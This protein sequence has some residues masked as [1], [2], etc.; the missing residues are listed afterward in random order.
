MKR[1]NLCLR[2]SYVLFFILFIQCSTNNKSTERITKRNSIL[3][4]IHPPKLQEYTTSILSF[5]AK[6]DSTTNCKPAFDKAMENCRIH[7]GAKITVPAGCYF[8]DGPIHLVN[9]VCIELKKGA[10]LKFSSKPASY[11]PVVLTSWEGTFLY[12]YSPYIYGYQLENISIIGEG[13][14]D[15]NAKD[16]ISKWVEVQEPDQMLTRKMNHENVPIKD[17]IF[18]SGHFLRPQLIQLFECKNILIEGVTI[19]NSP[20]WCVHLLKS[21]NVIIRG[22]SYNAQNK[23]NDG[24]D[25]EYSKN[26]LI[27][28]INFNNGD[29]NI[30]IKAGRD[31]EG[32]ATSIP[33]EN[34][35]IRNCRFRGLHG[36]VIG[37]EMSAG[38]RNVFVENCGY[39]GYC[40]RG[41]YLKSNP[42]RGGFITDIYFN[43][44]QFGQVEDCFFITSY[45][46]GEGKGFST[47]IHDI[48]IDSVSCKKAS[49]AGIIVQ[50]YPQNK[51]K[52]IYFSNIVIDSA[53]IGVNITNAQN[54]VF[55]EVAIGGEVTVPSHVK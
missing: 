27:E 44:V 20:F 12:N 30:A 5:G 45:Y 51:V 34:I 55:S 40:K 49:N 53:F 3:K 43:N 22:V 35:I 47:D 2:Y 33:S 48:Y 21:N 10:R 37:S 54:I 46:H 4:N 28:N 13:I 25:P 38:V 50:G 52:D 16:S 6:G 1:E 14:I 36:V 26:I 23:N 31:H 41:L 17:R 29:D 24:I 42:D 19:I 8:I 7:H 39:S 32:R 18:G 9:N 15:G 11:L